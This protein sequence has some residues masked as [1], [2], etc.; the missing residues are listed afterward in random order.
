MPTKSRLTAFQNQEGV[1]ERTK[2][3]RVLSGV[4]SLLYLD[5]GEISTHIVQL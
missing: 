4:Q 2:R 3:H 1:R 5:C